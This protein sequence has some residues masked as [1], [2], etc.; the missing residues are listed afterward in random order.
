MNDKP[1]PLYQCQEC[2]APALV[3][4]DVIVR[5]CDHLGSIVANASGAMKGASH[6][7]IQLNQKPG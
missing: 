6:A 2:G 5:Q 4:T 3:T 7:G 1:K